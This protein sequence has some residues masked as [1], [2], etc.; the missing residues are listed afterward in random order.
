[1]VSSKVVL[2]RDADYRNIK[3][4]KLCLLTRKVTGKFHCNILICHKFAT[5]RYQNIL[6]N[7]KFK[8]KK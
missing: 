6:K 4:E 7:T 8:A 2:D 5:T 1:M 3:E